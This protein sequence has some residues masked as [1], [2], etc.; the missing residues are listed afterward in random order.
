MD[1]TYLPE[2]NNQL[3]YMVLTI[4]FEYSLRRIFFYKD[5]PVI[6]PFL[7]VGLLYIYYRL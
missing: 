6:Q 7:S 2:I 5:K 3:K 4:R 1:K